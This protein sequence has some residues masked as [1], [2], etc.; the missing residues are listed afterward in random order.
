[1]PKVKLINQIYD[2]TPGKIFIVYGHKFIVN[3]NGEAIADVE[4]EFIN[5]EMGNGRYVLLDSQTNS[6]EDAQEKINSAGT[7][8]LQKFGY[9]VIDFYGADSLDDLYLKLGKLKKEHLGLFAKTRFNLE[10]PISMSKASHKIE[11]FRMIKEEYDKKQNKN[12]GTK[13]ENED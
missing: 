3:H 7:G 9:E 5:S 12:D 1:M 6:I 10:I 13:I 2:P 11:L 4:P 8:P